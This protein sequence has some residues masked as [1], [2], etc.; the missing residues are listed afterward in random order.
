M[1]RSDRGQQF[2]YASPSATR[3]ANGTDGDARRCHQDLD[4]PT[5]ADRFAVTKV[6]TGD[7]FLKDARSST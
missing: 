3:Y 4:A 6:A 1:V 7:E 5:S 2:Q